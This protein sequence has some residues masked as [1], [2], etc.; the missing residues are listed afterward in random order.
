MQ[1]N[2]ARWKWCVGVSSS[3]AASRRRALHA[4]GGGALL[5]RLRALTPLSQHPRRRGKGW[6]RISSSHWQLLGYSL[7]PLLDA[8]PAAAA[9]TIPL[10]PSPT[11]S[12]DWVVTYF[13]ST[14]FTPAGL[15]VYAR[16][17]RGVDQAKVEQLVSQL[18]L[19]GGEVGRLV[20]GGK[21]FRIPQEEDGAAEEVP[22]RS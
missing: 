1:G 11:P 15:D 21:M 22:K 8:H 10:G 6:L 18:E 19:L 2:G 14:L 5:V 17:P 12:P 16:D 7:S 3:C 20:Q 9:T 4:L 13:S